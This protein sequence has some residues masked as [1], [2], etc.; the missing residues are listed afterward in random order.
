MEISTEAARK[1]AARE[2]KTGVDG[3]VTRSSQLNWLVSRAIG[4]QRWPQTQMAACAVCACAASS[5][6]AQWVTIRAGWHRHAPPGFFADHVINSQ[7]AFS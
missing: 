6:V 3:S 7:S 1:T 2:R 5:V 4:K